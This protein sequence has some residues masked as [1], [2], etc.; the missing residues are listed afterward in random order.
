MNSGWIVT[1]DGP[2]PSEGRLIRPQRDE[3]AGLEATRVSMQNEALV[4]IV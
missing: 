3:D 4:R 1:C 2:R